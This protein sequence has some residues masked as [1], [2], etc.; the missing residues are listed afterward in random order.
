[1]KLEEYARYDGLG[2]AEL[3]ARR[4]VTPRELG[5]L[6]LAGIEKVNPR[7]N[8]VIETFPER[9]QKLAPHLRCRSGPFG[10]VP[11]LVK[12]FPIEK[13]VKGEMGCQLFAGFAPDQDSELMLRLRRAGFVNL[14][15]TASS[16]LGLAALTRS[17]QSGIT[18]N[19]WDPS[20]STA[21]STGGGAAAVRGRHRAHR[22]GRRRRRLDPQSGVLLRPG[23]AEAQ[24][25]AD[26]RRPR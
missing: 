22:P 4:E 9:L 18:R 1:M 24:P 8:A 25:R 21:G 23:G 6:A 7:L 20:R 19:P 3:V 10:G 13:G 2:L 11:L 15:R 14:G 17:R 16:E 12:D 26:Q 5:A